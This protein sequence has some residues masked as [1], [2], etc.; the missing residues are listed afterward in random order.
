MKQ[1]GSVYFAIVLLGLTV[2]FV[3]AGTFLESWSGSH[4]YAAYFTYNS[5]LFQLLL[6]LYFVNILFATLRRLPF[7][8]HHIPFI[9]T[10]LGLLMILAGVLCKSHFGLQGSMGI[11]EG[12]GAERI[13][14][15][16]TH[17]L[18]VESPDGRRIFP[19][20]PEMQSGPLSIKLVE[21]SE[22]SEESFEG[23]LKGEWGHIVG[24]PPIPLDG[25]PL[26]TTHYT[27]Q[28]A[29]GEPNAFTFTGKASLFFVRD[30]EE[31]EHLVA[32][33]NRGERFIH[34]FDNQAFL[35][36]DKGYGGYGV[37][38]ELPQTFP[39]IELTAPLTRLS[40]ALPPHKKKEE[41]IPR[42]RL[43]VSDQAQSELVTLTYDKFATGFKWPVL[44]GRYLMRFQSLEKVIP[45]HVRLRA[46]RQINY[47][48]TTQPYS[49]ESDL[50]I[51]GEEA[52]ISMNRVYEKNGYRFYLANLLTPPM[53]A[54]RAQ[55]VV[56]YDPVR[57]VLTYPGAVILALGMLLLYL[58]RRY[59]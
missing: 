2:L 17:A 30:S 13:F 52:T 11:A 12:S 43:L 18:L 9:I 54:K 39:P 47:P 24:L 16:N 58:R 50:L 46:A 59:G 41:L 40:K 53:G 37:F 49:F 6:W 55:I 15:P 31:K 35:I 33:N 25:P 56:N 10:H 38:A 23:F 14:L 28:A 8:L 57:Y 29:H 22:H 1:I 4:L 42:I 44:G 26:E 48:G 3:M 27:I 45:V 19:L 51:D 7:R 21:W 5:P 20:K 34:P 36:F 32:F